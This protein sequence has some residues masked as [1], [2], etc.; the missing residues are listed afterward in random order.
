VFKYFLF[1]YL[2]AEEFFTLPVELGRQNLGLCSTFKAF[3]EGDFYRATPAVTQGLGFS[4]FIR[5]TTLFGRLLPHTRGCGGPI[6]TRILTGPLSVTS[7]DI[8]EHAEYLLTSSRRVFKS[9]AP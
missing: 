8:Q 2:L 3:E 1:V 5:R 6:L 4:D 7:Y 9:L